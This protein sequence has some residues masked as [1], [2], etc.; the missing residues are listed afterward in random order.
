MIARW[1]HHDMAQTR[2]LTYEDLE[3]LP[4]DGKRREIV[5]GVLYVPPSPGVN[6]ARVVDEI[7]RAFGDYARA[8][9]GE[10]FA[11][12]LD[13]RL[14]EHDIVEPDVLY[15]APDRLDIEAERFLTGAPTIVVEVLSPSSRRYD[16]VTKRRLYARSG[17]PEYWVVDVEAR[18]VDRLTQ[19][20]GDDYVASETFTEGDVVPSVAAPGLAV[21]LRTVFARLR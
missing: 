21:E 20:V 15:V 11:S 16:R 5:D 19:P 7:G 8:H 13:T 10:A 14:G 12:I 6:H 9:G 18:S 17:V 1:Y 3:R 2:L 4:E